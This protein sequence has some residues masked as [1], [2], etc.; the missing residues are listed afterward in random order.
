MAWH[1]TLS[2]PLVEALLG[3]L[4][5]GLQRPRSPGHGDGR[6][7]SADHFDAMGGQAGVDHGGMGM[8]SGSY[9]RKRVCRLLNIVVRPS[10]ASRALTRVETA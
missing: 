2:H 5:E 4:A 3:E 9:P 8:A 6:K 1:P 7:R 10:V